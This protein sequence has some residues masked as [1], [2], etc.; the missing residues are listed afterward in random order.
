MQSIYKY[1]ITEKVNEISIINLP[2]GAK[3]L[4]VAQQN[5][6]IYMWAMVNPETVKLVPRL[7][8]VAFTGKKIPPEVVE[9]FKFI[10]TV[11]YCGEITPLVLHIFV[12]EGSK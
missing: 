9:N 12:K 11:H 2:K 8:Y 1:K 7:T 4:S 6:D 3:V 5:E 10:G